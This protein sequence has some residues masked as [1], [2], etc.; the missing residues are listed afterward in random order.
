MMRRENKKEGPQLMRVT[1]QPDLEKYL[2]IIGCGGH[3][4]SVTDVAESQGYININYLNEFGE[5][6]RFLGRKVIHD[7]PS[8]YEGE[9]FVAIGDNNTRERV[10]A[11]FLKK[12]P[13]AKLVSLIHPS[14]TVSKSTHVG[15]GVVVMPLCAINHSTEIGEGVIINTKSSI[16]HDCILG[17]YSSIA[18]G[19]C[20]GGNI[21]V[22]QRSA[23]SIGA[24]VKHGIKI[25]KDVVIG[26]N[27]LVL[28]NI[29]DFCVAYGLPAK[30]IRARR[31]GDKYL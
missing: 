17:D 22:G 27:S 30:R 23:V 18:P 6:D 16:D 15:R 26:A 29:K 21:T 24:T 4:K 10:T 3:S 9:F 31:Q 1:T 20:M 13:K 7:A 14:S 28:S 25:G 12:N 11:E 19:V 5:D 8:K 2:L